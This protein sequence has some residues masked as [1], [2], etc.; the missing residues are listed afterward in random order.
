[1]DFVRVLSSLSLNLCI[2]L[3]LVL[4]FFDMNVACQATVQVVEGALSKI[5]STV[6]N[7]KLR[8]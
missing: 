5:N 1:M 6:N 8:K 3:C 2:D 7:Y 4:C